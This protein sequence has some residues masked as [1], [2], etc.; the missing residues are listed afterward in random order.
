MSKHGGV[1]VDQ[2]TKTL[3]DQ[4]WLLLNQ[5][6][7]VNASEVFDKLFEKDKHNIAA[8]QGKIASLRK[9]REFAS[10]NEL[11]GK[12]LIV[13][14]HHPGILSERAWLHLDQKEYDDAVKAFD[15]VLKVNKSDQG[16]FLWKV[17]LLRGQR[18]FAE[19]E[20]AIREASKIFPDSLSLRNERGWLHFYQK[21]YDEAIEIFE[22]ILT[23]DADN[24]SALQG[25]IAAHRMKGQFAE[26]GKLV[27]KALSRFATSPGIHSESGWLNFEQGDY[28]KA[29]ADFKTVLAL[30][31]DDPFS[32]L[33]LA[34]SL[35]RQGN[36]DDFEKA[37][38]HCRK[39]L[40]LDPNLA[41]AFGCLGVVAF[42][43]GRIR[44]AEAYLL[45]SI[46]VD[47]KRG[48]FADLGALYIQM[49][50][51][52]EAKEKLEEAL[53]NSPDDAYAHTQM[54]NLYL[55]TEKVKEAIREFRLAMAID[56]NSPD[57]P[58]ALAI[59]LMESNNLIEAEKV[60]RTALR[61]LD[62]SKRWEL[63][64]VLCQ[65]LT[66]LG[67]EAGDLQFYEEALKEVSKAIRLKPK[68]PDPYF[69]GG[70]V[71]FKLEDYRGAL[72]NFRRS[73]KADEHYLEAELNARRVRSLIRRER[74]RSRTSFL[75]SF[76]LAV[77]F[78]A[79]LVALWILR[80]R[81]DKIPDAMLTVLVPILMGLMVVAVL[82]PWLSKIKMTGLEA[83]MSEPKPKEALASGPKGEI[84]F[85][86]ASPKSHQ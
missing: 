8:F 9:Q 62:Q 68:H 73:T 52:D 69:H 2:D 38:R 64:L 86:S 12:A 74:A 54:G 13:H 16:I 81:T 43:R 42:K 28:E 14:P 48:H 21:Q 20:E 30:A 79:Q 60:L 7:Y 6:E 10:A 78:L 80:F 27:D 57:S 31:P 22:E 65:L 34:W 61:V 11:L 72:T 1:A 59:A 50:R 82:L 70:V 44:E 55:Q 76:F 15:E 67:D 4:G 29:E 53:G 24:E 41:D 84:G 18:R 23:E 26:A 49:G 47:P 77:V 58:R 71:R 66:R 19:A 33:N 32:H 46:Q 37:T 40:A 17:S 85:G 75:A 25:R 3:E 63:H 39:A 51:Y 5:K 83:E 36:D 45:R 35:V 56:P